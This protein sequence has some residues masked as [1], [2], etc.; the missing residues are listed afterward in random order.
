M[1]DWDPRPAQ[2]WAQSPGVCAR[3][4][5]GLRVRDISP[6]SFSRP[7]SPPPH[8]LNSRPSVSSSQRHGLYPGSQAKAGQA[9]QG[10]G[11]LGQGQ[12]PEVLGEGERERQ[13]G[14]RLAHSSWSVHLYRGPTA[15]ASLLLG[16][17][18]CASSKAPLLPGI[19]S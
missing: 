5:L 17:V 11:L 13:G 16:L 4:L 2:G 10:W 12:G 9:G 8:F 6:V 1:P 15:P 7:L 14:S 3:W 18:L 19:R